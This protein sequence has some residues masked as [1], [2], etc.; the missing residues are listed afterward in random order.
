MTG[1]RQTIQ[2]SLALEPAHQG[3]TPVGGC[4]GTEPVV[5]KPA[6]QSPAL[7]PTPCRC[8]S[9][10]PSNRRVRDPM[11]GGVGGVAPRGVPLSRSSTRSRPSRSMEAD[12]D[13]RQ[14]RQPW[15]L[16]HVSNGRG[17][18]VP[19]QMS[20]EIQHPHRPTAGTAP[21]QHE[22]EIGSNATGDHGGGR[23]APRRKSTGWFDRLV[24][25]PRAIC[26]CSRRPKRR[27]W[28]PNCPES[29]ECRIM[30]PKRQRQRSAMWTWLSRACEIELTMS[31]I[32]DWTREG[33]DAVQDNG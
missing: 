1:T 13:R 16:R 33:E 17:G 23:L 3:E 26:R 24:R 29:A 18:P 21:R 11:P 14:G 2:Y 9:L 30:C 22:R 20:Q 5:V 15:P 6:P 28:S 31:T 32:S 25:T 12:R 8:P 19:R 10:T 7:A 27:F 4:Q